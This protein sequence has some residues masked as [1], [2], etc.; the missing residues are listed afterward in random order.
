MNPIPIGTARQIA[1]KYGLAIVCVFGFNADGTEVT[2]VEY[3]QTK[4]LCRLGTKFVDKVVDAL[5]C[6]DISLEDG[7]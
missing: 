4:R 1:E 7:K 3:G 5:E 6:G 2:A